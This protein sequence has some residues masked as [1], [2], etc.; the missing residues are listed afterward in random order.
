ML[1]PSGPNAE[2]IKYWNEVAGPKWVA[3]Q[4]RIDSH[5]RSL[6]RLAM[7]RAEI[8]PGERILD[9]GCGCGDTTLDLA[10]RVGPSGSVTGVDI[11]TIMIERARESASS[12]AVANTVFM[13][14]DAQIH[15]LPA[16]GF[17]V[18]YSRFGVMF[19]IDPEAAFVN[20][21]RALRPRGRL[22]FVCWR[23]LQE[24][25]WIL[26]P[27][28][29]AAQ[30]ITLPPPPPPDAPGPFS[31]A[32]QERVERILSRAGFLQLRFDKVDETLSVGGEV[33]LDQ[34]VDFLLQMGPLA[35]VLREI[36]A[37]PVPRVRA[38]V[39]K[40]LEPYSGAQGV[41]L[42]GA[43]WIVTARAPN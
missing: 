23:A 38:T 18:A 39:R 24:N 32:D 4:E 40:A 21:R 3:L 20:I 1:E 2:Q 10:R 7:E 42:Q 8:K 31:F 37:E 6:G 11:S 34:A 33:D 5:I 28:M 12:A 27:L 14:V 30:E 41:R 22:S 16:G 29:A 15:A 17:D 35:R 36:G 43:A 9:I 19:F 13:N 26:V 25:P